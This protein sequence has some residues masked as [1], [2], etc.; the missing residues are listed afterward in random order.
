MTFISKNKFLLIISAVFVCV[1]SSV[2]ADIYRTHI[3]ERDSSPDKYSYSN[4]TSLNA[5]PSAASR[6][7]NAK[8]NGTYGIGKS[9][10][11]SL[12]GHTCQIIGKKYETANTFRGQPAIGMQY[13]PA[14]NRQDFMVRY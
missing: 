3:Y 14:I 12:V 9:F 10:C 4:S 6:T 7:G 2:L 1:S 13:S 11:E 5:K 8:L